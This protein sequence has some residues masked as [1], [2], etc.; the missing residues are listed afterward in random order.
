MSQNSLGPEVPFVGPALYPSRSKHI[1]RYITLEPIALDH[2][3]GLWQ[4]IGGLENA[5]LW[6]Y[7]FEKPLLERQAFE[8]FIVHLLR[9]EK[10]PSF[11][12]LGNHIGKALGY[13]QLLNV[14]AANRVIEIGVMFSKLLQKTPAATECTYL[15]ARH[16]FE[17]LGYRRLQWKSNTL[18][19]ASRRAALRL[20]FTFEGVFRQ[21]YI[22]KGRSRD[23]A[24][25]SIIDSEWPILKWAFQVW[26][27]SENF[28]EEGRQ[29]V[30][31]ATLREAT[32][33]TSQQ[34]QLP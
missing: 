33:A 18:N 3:D 31:L 17:E 28:D 21:H 7:M 32:T 15:L 1:G 22:I 6:D 23:T 19:E 14:D 30:G 5:T 8:D 13:V 27:N 2:V 24:W 26:L 11:T 29:R 34:V 12:I 4:T 10:A 20:G 16:V 25:F 9:D